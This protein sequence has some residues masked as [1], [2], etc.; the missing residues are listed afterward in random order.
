MTDDVVDTL[1]GDVQSKA[2]QLVHYQQC[3]YF[4]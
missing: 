3:L 4:T 2:S 1:E